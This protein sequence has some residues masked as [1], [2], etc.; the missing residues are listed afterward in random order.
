MTM[1]RAYTNP[2]EGYVC[3]CWNAPSRD[4]LEELFRKAEAP[5]ESMHQVS[6]YSPGAYA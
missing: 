4:A 6:E 5:F 2:D 1:D 3:C